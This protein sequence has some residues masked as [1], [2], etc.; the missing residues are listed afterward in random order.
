MT[1]V[2]D[3][4][5]RP[6]ARLNDSTPSLAGAVERGRLRGNHDLGAEFLGLDEGAA[7][8]RLT[9]DAGGK[10]QVIF[11]SRAGPRLSTKRPTVQYDDVQAFRSRIH[12][13]RESRRAGAHDDHVVELVVLGRID[14]SKAAHNEL[15]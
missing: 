12:G 4:R 14:H 2:L 1:T 8:E 10:A 6:S 5:R 11:N 3:L 13:S 15:Y 7:R 9:G